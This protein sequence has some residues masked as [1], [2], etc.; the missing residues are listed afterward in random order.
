MQFEVVVSE[1]PILEPTQACLWIDVGADYIYIL[2]SNYF[3]RYRPLLLFPPKS[4]T[5]DS[6][7]NISRINV[8]NVF[9]VN[10]TP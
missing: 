7:S 3:P 8:Q 4:N 6:N 9:Q 10:A 2:H 1:N 5:S